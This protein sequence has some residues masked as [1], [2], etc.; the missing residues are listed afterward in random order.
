MQA[1]AAGWWCTN[2]I[3]LL[4]FRDKDEVRHRYFVDLL[5]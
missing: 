1:I 5:P 2:V 3:L 4:G